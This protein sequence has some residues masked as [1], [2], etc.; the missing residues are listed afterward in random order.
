MG[1]APAE[2]PEAYRAASPVHRPVHAGTVV[3]MGS[4]D[5]IIPY[6]LPRLGPHTLVAEPAGHF[7]WI[8]PGTPAWRRLERELEV[9]LR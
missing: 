5:P 1:G 4:D 2:K 6:R 3:L 7:D 9:L 8:H